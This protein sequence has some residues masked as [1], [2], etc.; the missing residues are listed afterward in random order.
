MKKPRLIAIHK[1]IN[2]ETVKI[3]LTGIIKEK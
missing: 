1:R 2:G 3:K